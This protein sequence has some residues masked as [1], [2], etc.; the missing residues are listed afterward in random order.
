[1]GDV[2]EDGVLVSFEADVGEELEDARDTEVV[3]LRTIEVVISRH[4]VGSS[5]DARSQDGVVS[6]GHAVKV[7]HHL[8]TLEGL[9]D[10]DRIIADRKGFFTGQRLCHQIDTHLTQGKEPLDVVVVLLEFV[11]ITP[12]GGVDVVDVVSIWSRGD[13][14]PEEP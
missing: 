7:E 2:G 1:M 14:V 11:V 4:P 3:V 5:R 12:P 13:L 6:E 8:E 10:Q 9:C